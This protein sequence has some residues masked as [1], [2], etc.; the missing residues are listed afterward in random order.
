MEC[1]EKNWTIV[2]YCVNVYKLLGPN[3]LFEP[4]KGKHFKMIIKKP[5]FSLLQLQ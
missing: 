4:T 2:L 3:E 5:Y 1:V